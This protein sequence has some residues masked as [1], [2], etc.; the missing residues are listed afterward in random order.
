MQDV[1]G[2]DEIRLTVVEPSPK[3]LFRGDPRC[4]ESSTQAI[5]LSLDQLRIG[6]DVFKQRYDKFLLHHR[7]DSPPPCPLIHRGVR[8]Q[9]SQ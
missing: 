1:V 7:F 2:E 5:Q 3:V 8:L 6:G 9:V 4:P